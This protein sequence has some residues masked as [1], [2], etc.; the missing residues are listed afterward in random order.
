VFPS[1]VMVRRKWQNR[2]TLR[3]WNVA[4]TRPLSGGNGLAAAL[5][6]PVLITVG[7][8]DF[9]AASPM[10]RACY[11]FTRPMQSSASDDAKQL[12]HQ[13]LSRERAPSR[14]LEVGCCEATSNLQ[15]SEVCLRVTTLHP[16]TA[17]PSFSTEA[18][19]STGRGQRGAPSGRGGCLRLGWRGRMRAVFG[20]RG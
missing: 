5:E 15:S 7:S 10:F 12:S 4:P 9:A 18:E 14:T 13:G 1:R 19:P 8:R 17:T 20:R 2:R 16:Q 3:R 11:Q 6:Q